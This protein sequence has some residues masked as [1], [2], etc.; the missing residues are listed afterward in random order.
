MNLK[1]QQFAILQYYIKNPEVIQA[2]QAKKIKQEHT[3]NRNKELLSGLENLKTQTSKLSTELS[4]EQLEHKFKKD[5][6]PILH[7]RTGTP[8]SS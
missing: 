1:L 8:K 2:K 6:K 3:E 7:V 5:E 4:L